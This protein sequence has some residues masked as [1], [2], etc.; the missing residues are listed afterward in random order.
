MTER[1]FATVIDETVEPQKITVELST[2]ESIQFI[3]SLYITTIEYTSIEE[4]FEEVFAPYMPCSPE[5][6]TTE[7]TTTKYPTEVIKPLNVIETKN[8][9]N[10]ILYIRV[11][12]R[13]DVEE[14]VQ[15]PFGLGRGSITKVE[16]G[17]TITSEFLMEV[18]KLPKLETTKLH[19]KQKLLGQKF[20]ISQ[21]SN[22]SPTLS[23]ASNHPLQ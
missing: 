2:Y 22:A 17:E 7:Y 18:Y 4:T 10:R 23:P 13:A 15:S 3:P 8:I 6:T 19:M 5:I 16:S 11:H 9:H 20:P 12:G 21:L 1:K 14:M